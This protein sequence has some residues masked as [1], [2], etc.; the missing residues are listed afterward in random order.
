MK[1]F[2]YSLKRHLLFLQ[3][4]HSSWLRL[5]HFTEK[6]NQGLGNTYASLLEA[7]SSATKTARKDDF[8]FIME[9]PLS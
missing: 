5:F 2:H 6:T 7:Y 8:I 4:Q 3:A 9:A 1:Y